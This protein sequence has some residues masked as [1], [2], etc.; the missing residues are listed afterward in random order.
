M[1]KTITAVET[2]GYGQYFVTKFQIFLS[3]DG[4]EFFQYQK[5]K[6]NVSF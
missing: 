5:G 2:E 4:K 6:Q 1:I 3:A